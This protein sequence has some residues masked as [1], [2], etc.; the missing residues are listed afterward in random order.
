VEESKGS[1]PCSKEYS[2]GE[3]E[4]SV[5]RTRDFGGRRMTGGGGEQ[6]QDR[7]HAHVLSARL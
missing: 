6:A 1:Q 2:R 4:Y 5:V 3:E 7:V